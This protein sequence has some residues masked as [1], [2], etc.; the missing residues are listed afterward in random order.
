T[1]VAGLAFL[2]PARRRVIAGFIMVVWHWGYLLNSEVGICSGSRLKI[3]A[4][5]PGG[6][7]VSLARPPFCRQCR[8][9]LALP[10]GYV[11]E[12]LIG[13]HERGR[14]AGIGR[15][16]ADDGVRVTGVI[17]DQAGAASG[18][19]GGDEGGAGASKGIEDDIP[20]L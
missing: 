17:F 6:L 14:L 2:E 8:R 11:L 10:H 3:C 7:A 4:R 20:S 16:A 5:T 9:L 18:L 15:E 1:G 19:L 12:A 13:S